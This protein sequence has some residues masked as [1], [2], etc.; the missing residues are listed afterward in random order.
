[1]KIKF[2]RSSQVESMRMQLTRRV[3]FVAGSVDY[4]SVEKPWEL[5]IP[6]SA[7]CYPDKVCTQ[8]RKESNPNQTVSQYIHPLP[9]RLR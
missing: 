7:P 9:P 8:K 5:L 3:Y 1:M 4:N 6:Y 2:G